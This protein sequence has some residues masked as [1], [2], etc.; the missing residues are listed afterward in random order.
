MKKRY[1]SRRSDFFTT[2]KFPDLVT[3]AVRHPTEARLGF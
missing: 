3:L 1:L 2:D